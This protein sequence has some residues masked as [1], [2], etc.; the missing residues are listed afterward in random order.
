MEHREELWDKTGRN[1][2]SRLQLHAALG[3]LALST[4][5]S[6]SASEL[7]GRDLY[8]PSLIHTSPLFIWFHTIPII[9]PPVCLLFLLCA[10]LWPA[11][12]QAQCY[13]AVTSVRKQKSS[14]C[15]SL[16]I[17]T[18]LAGANPYSQMLKWIRE[19]R[20]CCQWT[21]APTHRQVKVQITGWEQTNRRM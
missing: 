18:T 19:V 14:Q 7:M 20:P 17:F 12:A 13:T 2:P 6:T 11:P 1:L 15:N 16:T 21:H 4:P 10:L 8:F 5:P 3:G 9:P